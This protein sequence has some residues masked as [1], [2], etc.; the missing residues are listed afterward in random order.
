MLSTTVEASRRRIGRPWIRSSTSW[1]S[2]TALA[3]LATQT[4]NP[5]AALSP[6]R[7]ASSYAMRAAA[8]PNW[9][10]RP[11]GVSRS[12]AGSNPLTSAAT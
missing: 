6:A 2:A 11:A 4:A 7:P 10:N 1:N 3:P 12:P 8:M 9:A 5:L